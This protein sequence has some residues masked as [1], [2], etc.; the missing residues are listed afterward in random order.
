MPSNNSKFDP[1]IIFENF[2]KSLSPKQ[3]TETLKKLNE[4]KTMNSN[5]N[6]K[7][8]NSRSITPPPFKGKRPLNSPD[9]PNYGRSYKEKRG[10]GKSYQVSYFQ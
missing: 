3:Q 7:D 10:N 9:T 2:F 6:I 1:A 5:N 8:I 4:I